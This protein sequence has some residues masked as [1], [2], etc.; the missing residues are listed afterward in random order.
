MCF[1]TRES[2]L[3]TVSLCPLMSRRSEGTVLLY[4]ELL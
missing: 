4:D 2:G 3:A 1:G